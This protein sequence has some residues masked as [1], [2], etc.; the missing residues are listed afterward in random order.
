[1]FEGELEMTSVK[2]IDWDGDL[3]CFVPARFVFVIVDD[4][5][6]LVLRHDAAA[7]MHHSWD[8]PGKQIENVKAP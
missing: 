5:P 7:Q 6:V 8:W 4:A 3:E 1:M 2:L